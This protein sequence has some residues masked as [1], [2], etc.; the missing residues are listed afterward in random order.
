MSF[1]LSTTAAAFAIGATAVLAGSHEPKQDSNVTARQAHMT[2][3]SYN[4]GTLGGMAKGE[5]EYDAEIATTAA[6]R[7]HTLATMSQ[8]GYWADG[9]ST[10]DLDYSRALPVL[11]SEPEKYQE[12]TDDLAATA[13]EMQ[14]AAGES[15]EAIGGQMKAVGDACGACHEDFRQSDD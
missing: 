15:A 5:I 4:L 10:E 8:A 3:Y 7:I 1:K 2:L 12:F 9:T 14:T 13:M 6:T 11:F